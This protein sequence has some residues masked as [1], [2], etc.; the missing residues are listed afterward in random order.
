[1]LKGTALG[2]VGVTL[3]AT[4]I[5]SFARAGSADSI[6][7]EKAYA[8]EL[9]AQIQQENNK[10]SQLNESYDQAQIKLQQIDGL[11]TNKVSVSH[12]DDAVQKDMATLRDQALDEYMSGGSQS[13]IAQLFSGAGTSQSDAQEYQN[14]AGG[15]ISSLI[16]QLHVDQQTLD[17]QR[18]SSTQQS[19]SR[20]SRSPC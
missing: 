2:L 12:A 16:D 15:N 17:V 13:G 8:A 4:A 19:P 20:S 7:S 1:M 14:L 5:F 6:S 3:I 9:V 11:T 10:I 18:I